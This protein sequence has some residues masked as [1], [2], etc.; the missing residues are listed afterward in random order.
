MPKDSIMHQG[1]SPDGFVESKPTTQP[2]TLHPQSPG[3]VPV[4]RYL[5]HHL[6]VLEWDGLALWVLAG[7]IHVGP[8]FNPKNPA[9]RIQVLGPRVSG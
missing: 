9:S 4:W 5:H 7:F 2:Q 3:P 6:G 1:M 8:G